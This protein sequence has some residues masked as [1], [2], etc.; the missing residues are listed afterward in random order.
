[1]STL[2]SFL[3]S[4]CARCGTKRGLYKINGERWLCL[5]CLKEGEYK[6]SW[7][8][9]K[10]HISDTYNFC[11]EDRESIYLK[12]MEE[13]DEVLKYRIMLDQGEITREEFDEKAS[14]FFDNK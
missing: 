3:T 2:F 10:T 14:G 7:A 12:L 5:E 8:D 1:M 13:S 11:K 9:I 6:E 4:E